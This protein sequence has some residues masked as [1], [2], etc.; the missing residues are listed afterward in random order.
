MITRLEIKG[1]KT[2]ADVSIELGAVNVLIRGE[3][4]W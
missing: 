4:E 3:W 2:L 1:F